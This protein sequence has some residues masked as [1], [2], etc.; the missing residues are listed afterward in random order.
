MKEKIIYI[1]RDFEKAEM[2]NELYLAEIADEIIK[3][4]KKENTVTDFEHNDY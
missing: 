4:I 3:A 1:L 2:L